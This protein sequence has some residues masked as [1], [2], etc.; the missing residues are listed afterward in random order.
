MNPGDKAPQTHQ[1]LLITQLSSLNCMGL[2]SAKIRTNT[3]FGTECYPP[4]PLHPPSLGYPHR[5]QINP[6]FLHQSSHP[7]NNQPY[8]QRIRQDA[9]DTI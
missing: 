2:R 9:R 5:H 6:L 1:P 3:L 8:L 7:I 4:F